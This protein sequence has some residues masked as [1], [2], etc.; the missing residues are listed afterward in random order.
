MF[1]IVTIA[2]PTLFD[3]LRQTIVQSH[4]KVTVGRLNGS[5]FIVLLLG[6]L[7][8]ILHRNLSSVP[9]TEF[10]LIRLGSICLRAVSVIS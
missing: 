7:K 9:F 1:L 8:T 2:F 4:L 5:K 3:I 6:F 10:P